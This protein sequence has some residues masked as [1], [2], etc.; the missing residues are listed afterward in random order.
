MVN[1]VIFVDTSAFYALEVA[2]DVNHNKARNFLNELRSK[3]YGLMVT[4]NYILSETYTL[5]W[6]KKSA[7]IAIR[8]LDKI[9]RSRSIKVIWI[10]KTI[11]TMALEYAKKFSDLKLSY[12]DCTSFVVMSLFKIRNAFSFDTHF[13]SVG[14][15]KLP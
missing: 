7:T 11:F 2:T 10:D 1:N 15:V 12:V 6:M 13:R 4:T 5:M 3:K 14:F 9:S 8:F